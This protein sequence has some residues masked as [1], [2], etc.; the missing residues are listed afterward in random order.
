MVL[1]ANEM[2]LCPFQG[3]TFLFFDQFKSVP[4]YLLL[5]DADEHYVIDVLVYHI[6]LRYAGETAE[7]VSLVFLLVRFTLFV[8]FLVIT[9]LPYT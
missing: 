1:Y 8:I 4:R 3:I 5:R 2:K 6:E 9:K 7:S